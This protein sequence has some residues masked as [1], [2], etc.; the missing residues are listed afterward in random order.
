MPC[1]LDFGG[2]RLI[3]N[4]RYIGRVGMYFLNLR[5]RVVQAF[6]T[7]WC[8]NLVMLAKQGWRLLHDN[9]SLLNECFK[10]RNFPRCSFLEATDAPSSYLWKSLIAA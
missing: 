6:E 3:M 7:I 10:V 1:V 9:G 4:G 8:F 5:R 2:D